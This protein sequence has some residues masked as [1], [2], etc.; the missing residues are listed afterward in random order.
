MNAVAIPRSAHWPFRAFLAVAV[1]Q[2]AMQ[3]SHAQIKVDADFPGGNIVVE[4]IQGDTVL[5]RQ[6]P[7]D[8]QG[9]WFYWYFRVRGAAGR[10]LNFTFTGGDV[11]GVRGPAASM[12]GGRTW[13][14]LET[15][16]MADK[17]VGV[18]HHIAMTWDGDRMTAYLDGK[19]AGEAAVKMAPAAGP[20][21]IG[22]RGHGVTSFFN[23]LIDEV[24]IYNRPLSSEEIQGAM[25]GRNAE[26][27]ALHLPFDEGQGNAAEDRSDNRNHGALRGGAKWV[28]GKLGKALE[29][30]GTDSF[31]EIANDE[32]LN[33]V[34]GLTVSAWVKP[35]KRVE[36]GGIVDKWE[37][38]GG[39]AFK[40]YLIQSSLTSSI[41]TL[42]GAGDAYKSVKI[43]GPMFRYAFPGDADDVRFS[44]AMPYVER[45]LREFLDGYK[46][47]PNL[48][49]GLLCK[50]K[51]GRDVEVLRLGALRAEPKYRAL[52]TCR[53]HACE[54]MASYVLEGIMAEVL[55]DTQVGRWLRENVEFLV[56]PFADKDGVEDGDQGKNRIPH[57][58]NEDYYGESIYPETAAVREHAVKWL[59]NCPCFGFDLHCPAIRGGAHEH[60]MSPSRTRDPENWRFLKPFLEILEQTRTGPLEFKLAVSEQFISWDGK[61]PDPKTLPRSA[62][63]WMRTLPNM[64][65]ALVFEIPY[66]NASG[67]EVNQ[68]TARIWG[69]DFA[70]AFHRYLVEHCP[71]RPARE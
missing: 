11:L 7:R 33:S 67:K 58:H 29:F 22:K 36:Y 19:A 55:A 54:M 40:G 20:M 14:W 46:D 63:R 12:D 26:K 59:G 28:D 6:D 48:Q 13:K 43:D 16:S 21:F 38:D 2:A 70:V 9:F 42:I 25:A 5:L 17:N 50:S 65:G 60:I 61:L 56:V 34:D 45:N 3:G 68:E 4:S 18:W 64:Q 44:F 53:H 62:C 23:G 15:E 49:V 24:L 47:N 30:N 66:A 1:L 10:T 39:R 69:R 32:A 8:T 31:V 51:K 52:F 27:P 35:Y 57:D 41:S 37:Q 71:L